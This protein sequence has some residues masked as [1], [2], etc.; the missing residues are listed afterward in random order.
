MKVLV[1]LLLRL[2]VPRTVNIAQDA[3]VLGELDT[4]LSDAVAALN[5]IHSVPKQFHTGDWTF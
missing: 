3:E 4:G 2:A 5:S 1:L